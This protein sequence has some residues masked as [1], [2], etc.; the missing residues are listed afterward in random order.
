[1]ARVFS[2]PAIA[3]PCLDP[4]LVATEPA[5]LVVLESK[6]ISED[7]APPSRDVRRK[8]DAASERAFHLFHDVLQ[9]IHEALQLI[10]DRRD[11]AGLV[12]GHACN[13]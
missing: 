3:R 8:N 9:T 4:G 12:L 13:G 1:M 11:V 7:M 6:M 2:I 5:E 10:L